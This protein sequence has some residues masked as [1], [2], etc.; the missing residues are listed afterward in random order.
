MLETLKLRGEFLGDHVS[1]Y[2]AGWTFYMLG[3][4]LMMSGFL[5]QILQVDVFLVIGILPVLWF[6]L[7]AVLR[8]SL[9]SLPWIMSLGL[10]AELFLVSLFQLKKESVQFFLQIG[11][12]LTKCFIAFDGFEKLILET[13][14][15]LLLL[16]ILFS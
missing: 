6:C 8:T 9:R 2:L 10:P 7:I 13:D 12:L 15:F 16:C 1:V 3:S 4:D 11:E 14:D 5:R